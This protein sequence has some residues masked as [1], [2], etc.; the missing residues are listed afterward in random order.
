M[1]ELNV[2]NG[3]IE[4]IKPQILNNNKWEEVGIKNIS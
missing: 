4:K 3:K 1:Y 2:K